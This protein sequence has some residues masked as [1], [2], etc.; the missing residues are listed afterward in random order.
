MRTATDW[1]GHSDLERDRLNL[2][3]ISA[4]LSKAAPKRRMFFDHPAIGGICAAQHQE[5][6]FELRRGNK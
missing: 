2:A 3:Q 1:V 4:S 5:A 6:C